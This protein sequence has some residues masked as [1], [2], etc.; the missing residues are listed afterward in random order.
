MQAHG[1]VL[2]KASLLL[3]CIHYPSI[4]L[5]SL[6]PFPNL[7]LTLCSDVSPLFPFSS[8][9]V[10]SVLFSFSLSLSRVSSGIIYQQQNLDFLSYF[11]CKLDRHTW[12]CSCPWSQKWSCFT[13]A[14]LAGVFKSSWCLLIPCLFEEKKWQLN[15]NLGFLQFRPNLKYYCVLTEIYFQFFFHLWWIDCML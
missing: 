2:S 11:C 5:L 9:A 6:F 12:K 14:V 3:I 1:M 15:I 10:F 8:Y 7:P 4:P 13:V